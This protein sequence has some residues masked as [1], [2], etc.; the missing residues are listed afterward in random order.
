MAI[1]D[2]LEE[3]I[4]K[5]KAAGYSD[6]Q[7]KT[8]LRAQNVTV[9][10][11]SLVK[12]VVKAAATVTDKLGLRH[13]SDVIADDINN[14]VHPKLMEATNGPKR[15]MLDNARAGA[16]LGLAT[17]G[18]EFGGAAAAVA[19]TSTKVAARKVAATAGKGLEATGQKIQQSVIR[20]SIADIKDGFDI[21]NVAKHD[22]GGTL[23]E[24]I[25]KTHAKMNELGKQLAV[26]LKA[27][28]AKIDINET[29]AETAKRLGTDKAGSFGDNAAL[30]RVLDQIGDEILR[31]GSV[32]HDLVSATN[33]KRAAGSKGAWAYNRP[34]ADA[35][36]TERAYTAFYSVL[37][38]Q[39]E[40]AAPEGVK[41]INKQL[42]ELIPIQ[43]AALRRLPVEQR[44]NV[45]SLTDSLGFL[46][47]VFDPKALLLVGAS[48]AARSGKV[49]KVLTN[50]GRKMQ[51]KK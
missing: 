36:A 44:N 50:A 1:T 25:A 6:D 43:N 31:T 45:F 28:D 32:K 2:N 30:D 24:T 39:I 34:E 41:E 9:P 29:L 35:A 15:S 51:G 17:A 7:I 22:V 4:K 19:K 33:I 40:K 47:A 26:K 42:S 16:E 18:G 11:T 21:Q 46:S 14:I 48:K 8:Y 37:K 13:A 3:K 10:K 38:E 27:T 49:A 23:P 20:P 12:K 5:A